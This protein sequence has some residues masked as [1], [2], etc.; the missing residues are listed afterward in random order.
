ML[1]GFK[2]PKCNGREI[3]FAD[4]LREGGCI[5][6]DGQRCLSRSSLNLISRVRKYEPKY[7]CPNCKEEVR[8]ENNNAWLKL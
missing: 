8:V 7:V 6:S 3:K 4:C 1:K 5:A 2:C